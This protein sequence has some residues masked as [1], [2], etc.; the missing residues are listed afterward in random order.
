MTVMVLYFKNALRKD[1]TAPRLKN[2]SL[3]SCTM[4]IRSGFEV[5]DN[6]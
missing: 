4:N 2:L 3:S 6:E 5:D 1:T